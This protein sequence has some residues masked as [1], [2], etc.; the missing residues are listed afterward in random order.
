MIEDVLSINKKDGFALACQNEGG[1]KWRCGSCNWGVFYVFPKEHQGY[2]SPRPRK[3]RVC[4]ARF[5]VKEI[6][7]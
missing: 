3:C 5:I 6:S 2:Q 1:F 7:R 4:S